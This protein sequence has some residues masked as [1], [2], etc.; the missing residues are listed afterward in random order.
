MNDNN[1]PTMKLLEG[2]MHEVLG[3]RE[4]VTKLQSEV[5]LLRAEHEVQFHYMEELKAMLTSNLKHGN[6]THE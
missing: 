5:D 6:G 3:L 1:N 4:Q 2:I